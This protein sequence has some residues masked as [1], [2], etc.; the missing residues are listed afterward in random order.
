MR[1]WAPVAA[2]AAVVV[3]AA[4]AVGLAR[5][6]SDGGQAAAG[7]P[8]APGTSAAGPGGPGAPGASGAPGGPGASGAPGAPGAS[9]APGG[10]GASGAPGAFGKAA[11]LLVRDGDTVTGAGV[12]VFAPG[13]P[14]RFCAA[15]ATR[16]SYPPMPPECPEKGFDVTGAD[17]GR[18]ANAKTYE[19]TRWGN[20]QV[21]G[22]LSGGTLTLTDQRAGSLPERSFTLPDEPPCPAPR[23]GWAKDSS[24][25]GAG[26]LQAYIGAHPTEFGELVVTYPDGVEGKVPPPGA[27]QVMLVTTVLDVRTAEARLRTVYRGNLCVGTAPRS[28]AAVD[29]V[30]TKLSGPASEGAWLRH[31]IHTGAPDYLAGRMRLELLMVDAD[32]LAWLRAADPTGLVDVRPSLRPAR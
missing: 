26:V 13:A 15:G 8:D 25:S 10:P 3:V 12:L 16:L 18:L 5:L 2:A 11:D 32:L 22:R 17:P 7:P 27:T 4:G 14:V 6:G 29:V 31:G 23:G 9:G 28:R 1:R 24:G 20:A 21:T 19:D 30:W